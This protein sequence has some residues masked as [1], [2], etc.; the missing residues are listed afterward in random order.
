MNKP[1]VITTETK[2][3][4]PR[5]T[6]ARVGY[7]G[8]RGQRP[9][10]IIRGQD[11]T[12]WK[13]VYHVVLTASWPV[14][15]LGIAGVFFGVNAIFAGL[16]LLQPHAIVNAR[17]GSFLDAYF[18]SIQTFGSIGY[19]VLSPRT[20]YANFIVSVESFTSLLTAAIATGLLFA[21]FSRPFARVVFSNVAVIGPLE[22]VPTLMVRAANQR[23]NQMLDARA[24]VSLAR[25]VTTREGVTMRRFQELK[26]VRPRTPLFS[27]SWTIMHQ[28]DEHS[29]LHGVTIDTLYDQGMEIIVLLSGTD[30]T[31]AQVIYARHSYRAD[32]ILFGRR[33]ADVLKTGDTG[34]PEVD[35]RR[36]HDTVELS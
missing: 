2:V 24:T 26:L 29:P 8:R 34:R 1:P 12:Q 33:F 10:P 23:V 16:Y 19:G 36:F 4:P 21:R 28:I 35:L 7:A 17:P 13:D 25:Q 14:F 32:D 27:L 3:E 9:R 30:E 18:F 11:G 5:F 6:T 22:G 15:F 20:T 31:L